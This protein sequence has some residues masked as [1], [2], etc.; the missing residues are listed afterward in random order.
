MREL[1]DRC[2]F[3]DAGSAVVLAVSGGADSV[4][5]TLLALAAGLRPTLHH[6]NHHLR[7]DSDH[8]AEVVRTLGA[9]LGCAVVVHDVTVAS[10]S[11]VEAR[12]R[13]ERRRVMP[14]ESMTGHTMDDLAETVVLNMMRGA[15]VDGLSPL[16]GEPTKPLLAVRRAELLDCVKS[17]GREFVVDTTNAD[18]RLRRNRVRHETLPAMCVAAGRDVVPILAR[19]ATL[20]GDERAWLDALVRDGPPF[21]DADCRA[22]ATWPVA[23]LRRWVRGQL[24][25]HD[26]LDEHPLSADEVD[27]IIDVIAG[28]A[29]ATQVSGGR[30]V[31]RSGQRLGVFRD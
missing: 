6:V 23:R 5:L 4:G 20:M 8:D 24:T 25:T 11:N 31:A 18:L 10:G 26:G 19:Q 28:R 17:S 1:V 22:L 14:P 21:A 30:R 3:P 13:A 16:V 12:A 15:G 9:D 29:V 7:S 27:R 2:R